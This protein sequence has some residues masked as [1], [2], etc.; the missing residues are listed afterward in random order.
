MVDS[1][2]TDGENQYGFLSSRA[3]MFFTMNKRASNDATL[4]T[5]YYFQF[6]DKNL[7]KESV[8]NSYVQIAPKSNALTPYGFVHEWC[9]PIAGSLLIRTMRGCLGATTIYG[10]LSFSWSPT[11]VTPTTAQRPG[12]GCAEQRATHQDLKTKRDTTD[13][14]R[15]DNN[16][17]I[18]THTRMAA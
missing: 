5:C 11:E 13:G 3:A 17:I 12:T 10:Y 2:L 6:G 4:M 8:A 1:A 16:S 14:G 15:C 18:S 9:A 7:L